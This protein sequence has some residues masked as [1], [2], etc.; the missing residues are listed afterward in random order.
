MG[1]AVFET[2]PHCGERFQ[3]RQVGEKPGKGAAICSNCAGKGVVDGIVC[4]N[5][6]GAGSLPV[7]HTTGE[8][9]DECA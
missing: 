5:C 8:Y 1:T 2:C 3:V 9:R 4:R 6:H 7:F